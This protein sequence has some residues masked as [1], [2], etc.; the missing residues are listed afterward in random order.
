MHSAHSSSA[1]LRCVGVTAALLNLRLTKSG[2][3][4]WGRSHANDKPKSFYEGWGCNLPRKMLALANG[5]MKVFDGWFE[6]KQRIDMRR[7]E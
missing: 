4:R 2:L 7:G 6:L 1:S 5:M 3:T